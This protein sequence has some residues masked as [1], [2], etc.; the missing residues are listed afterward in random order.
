MNS[1]DKYN[2]EK[3]NSIDELTS[4][5]TPKY[6]FDDTEEKQS[7]EYSVSQ[8]F[9]DNEKEI[10]L[11]VQKRG[12]NKM[13]CSK[14]GNIMADDDAFCSVCGAKRPRHFVAPNQ[15]GRFQEP[16]MPTAPIQQPVQYGDVPVPNNKNN[17]NNTAKII[18]AIAVVTVV[19]VAAII[20]TLVLISKKDDTPYLPET[21][22]DISTYSTTQEDNDYKKENNKDYTT[23]KKSF[24]DQ[25]DSGLRSIINSSKAGDIEL[26]VIDIETGELNTYGSSSSDTA[27]AL[28]L[29]PVLLAYAQEIDNG[30]MSSDESIVI[31]NATNGRG[32][33]N[34]S[35]NGKVYSID[36]LFRIAFE[37]SDNT[38]MNALISNLGFDVIENVCHDEGYYSV[39]VEKFVG[40]DSYKG[41]NNTISSSDLAKMIR[42]MIHDN[43]FADSMM[44]SYGM[45]RD[46]SIMGMGKIFKGASAD[47]N[48]Y[49]GYVYDEA[50]RIK[51]S[52][53]D[54][55]IVLISESGSCEHGK[56]TAEEVGAYLKT[57]ID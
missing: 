55:V 11:D 52:K 29:Y 32:I 1:K 14:C 25:T 53:G 50:M 31:E 44:N 37:Y 45:I 48:G 15:S 34:S 19:I 6:E 36:D 39:R 22:S 13:I 51:G 10:E 2:A 24:M 33:L 5:N 18:I 3:W 49:T 47:L 35:D 23:E 57:C 40:I 56:K 9:V 26:S 7:N 16:T 27:S 43:G 42:Q 38:A 8:E 4:A 54:Y 17:A 21:T 30:Y 12:E 20:T 41:A 46:K 28:V